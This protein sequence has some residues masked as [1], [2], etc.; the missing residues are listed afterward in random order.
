MT[1]VCNIGQFSPGF[2]IRVPLEKDL[3]KAMNFV[4]GINLSVHFDKQ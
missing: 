2:H 3:G 4:Y 1:T